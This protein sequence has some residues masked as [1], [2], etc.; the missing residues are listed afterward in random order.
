MD[1]HLY[2]LMDFTP[3][4]RTYLHLSW[5][6]CW[7]CSYG[8]CLLLSNRFFAMFATLKVRL[9]SYLSLYLMLKLKVDT[10]NTAFSRLFLLFVLLF[11]RYLWYRWYATACKAVIQHL[12]VL[13]LFIQHLEVL[14]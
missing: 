7:I 5:C 8:C 9:F 6:F 10:F 11:L 2:L 14:L 1:V 12:L 3:K 4:I 13:V